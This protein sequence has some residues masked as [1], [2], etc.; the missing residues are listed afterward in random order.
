MMSIEDSSIQVPKAKIALDKLF[1]FAMT[2]TLPSSL[3]SM[4]THAGTH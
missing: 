3:Q 4:R 2:G 1:A